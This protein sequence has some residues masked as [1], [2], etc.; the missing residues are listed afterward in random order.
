MRFQQTHNQG[1]IKIKDPR[2]LKKV[3][4][5]QTHN[6]GHGAETDMRELLVGTEE[7]SISPHGVIDFSSGQ[8]IDVLHKKIKE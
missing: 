3:H 8:I 4:L 5:Q 2:R 1:S 7:N 6:Q